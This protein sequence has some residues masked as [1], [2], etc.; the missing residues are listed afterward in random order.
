[1]NYKVCLVLVLVSFFSDSLVRAKSLDRDQK[2]D[3]TTL[4]RLMATTITHTTTLKRLMVTT[5]THTTTLK[6]LMVSVTTMAT[7][8]KRLMATTITHTTT[9]K[10]LMATTMATTLKRPMGHTNTDILQTE[11]ISRW[12]CTML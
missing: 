8:L 2:A 1:M 3:A 9:L 5:I 6:R 12:N 7:T 11:S 10:R 4:K